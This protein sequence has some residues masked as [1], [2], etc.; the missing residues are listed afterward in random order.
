[1]YLSAIKFFHQYVGQKYCPKGSKKVYLTITDCLHTSIDC[2]HLINHWLLTPTP[3]PPVD[4][5]SEPVR[6]SG[7]LERALG[8]PGPYVIILKIFSPKKLGKLSLLT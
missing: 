4:A 5:L 6:S 8:R 2:L 3:D 7:C 1:M